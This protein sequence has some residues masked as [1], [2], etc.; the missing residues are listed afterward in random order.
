MSIW[1]KLFQN[2]FSFFEAGINIK[3]P[4]KSDNKALIIADIRNDEDFASS[5]VALAAKMAKADG[6]ATI[7]EALAFEAAFPIAK[8]DKP[9]FEKLF[10]LAAG[11]T[12][13]FE[14]YAKKIAKKYRGNRQI[15]FDV[16]AVLF[17][18]AVADGQIKEAEKQY[19]VDVSQYLG[20]TGSDYS[21]ISAFFIKDVEPNP[22]VI[23]GV[24]ETDTDEV[25]KRAWLDIVTK[26]HPDSFM[27]RGEP[28][29]FIRLAHET[30]AQ[31]NAAYNKIRSDRLSK[32][33]V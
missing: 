18:V 31:A 30:T 1:K 10:R 29:E 11:T 16:M 20:L 32:V 15:L 24:H 26:N 25:V 23:L 3:K 4:A 22:Y 27:S 19:L 6:I 9:A 2:P 8:E 28:K 21:R 7:D 12:L 14:H 5:V 17:F 13:G 33:A